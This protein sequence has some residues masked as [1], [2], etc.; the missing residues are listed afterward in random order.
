MI[1]HGML[2]KEASSVG[3]MF[4]KKKAPSRDPPSLIKPPSPCW[5]YAS[6]FWPG[7]AP[8]PRSHDGIAMGVPEDA[9][10]IVAVEVIDLVVLLVVVGLNRRL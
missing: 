2:N 4:A 6:H 1:F 3:S 7:G 8:A 5:L 9:Q 10:A